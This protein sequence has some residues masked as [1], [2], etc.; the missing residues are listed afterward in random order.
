MKNKTRMIITLLSSGLVFAFGVFR[1]LF[2]S[3]NSTSLFVA[4][5][6]AITG[7]IGVVA[8]GKLLRK[9]HHN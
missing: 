3:L 7:F 8:N 4:Y 6:F 9:S 5:V 2:E 1:I